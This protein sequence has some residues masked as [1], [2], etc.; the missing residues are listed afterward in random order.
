[1]RTAIAVI[2]VALAS[3]VPSA[4]VRLADEHDRAAF[5][6]WF[7]LLADLQF[8]QPAADVA[9]CAAL[10]RFAFREAMRAHTPEWSRRIG[11][12]FTPRFADVRSAPRAG[13]NGWPL[14]RINNGT[15]P[16]YAEFADAQTLIALNTTA[17][18]RDV[19]HARPGDLL[20]FRQPS[21]TQPDH[22]MV[23]VGRSHFDPDANDWVVYHTGPSD[24]DAGEVRKV[25]LATLAQHPAPRWRPLAANPQFVGVFRLTALTTP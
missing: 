18:G 23:F 4:Q 3:A 6:D 9:D 16:R 25:R 10:V 12:P 22:I 17:I 20:Y 1:M 24:D 13:D 14:F 2:V 8:E 11:L 5:R 21:Q 19:S 15:T 7:T